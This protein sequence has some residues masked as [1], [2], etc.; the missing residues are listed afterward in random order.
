LFNIA[1]SGAK[2]DDRKA[3]GIWLNVNSKLSDKV[4]SVI[5][6]G[7][8]KNQTEDLADGAV[9]SNTVIYGDLIFPVAQG[10]SVAIELMN[11]STGI[12]GADS[13]SALVFNV[14][15]KVNF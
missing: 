6:F 7:M 11:I 12:K 4:S 10:M 14:A 5:G 8:D 3:L 9:E 15:G 1:G 13:N 2:D